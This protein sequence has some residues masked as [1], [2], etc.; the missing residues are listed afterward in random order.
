MDQ[1]RPQELAKHGKTL[2]STRNMATMRCIVA[3]ANGLKHALCLEKEPI[4]VNPGS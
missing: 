3:D 4:S 1:G 2:F